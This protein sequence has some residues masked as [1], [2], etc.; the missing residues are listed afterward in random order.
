MSGVGQWTAFLG[1]MSVQDVLTPHVPLPHSVLAFVALLGWDLLGLGKRTL[2]VPDSNHTGIG[3][4]VDKVLQAGDLQP[5]S[6]CE[7]KTHGG[8]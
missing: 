4:L 1:T 6:G 5:D 2:L 7:M 3:Q 8:Q